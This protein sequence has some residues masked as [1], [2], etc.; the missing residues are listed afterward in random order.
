MHTKTSARHRAPMTFETS[1]L[2]A[3]ARSLAPFPG[4]D[5]DLVIRHLDAVA[6]LHG[7]HAAEPTPTSRV[8]NLA[9]FRVL[10]TDIEVTR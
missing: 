5:S 10:H 3:V 8:L 4:A 1:M 2:E 6:T 9:A 7:R